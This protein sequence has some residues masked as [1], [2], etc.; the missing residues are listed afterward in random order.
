MMG[1]SAMQRANDFDAV[2]VGLGESGLASACHLAAGGRRVA[3]LDSRPQP[4][5]EAE[6][7]RRHPEVMVR[8]GGIDETLIARAAEIVISPGFDPRHPAIREARRRGQ[9]VI[10]EIELFA[11]SVTAPVMA[12]TG[13]NG[14]STVTR[15]LAAMAEAAG[16]NV[17]AGGNLGPAALTLLETRPEAA[18]FILE[19]SSFQLESTFSLTPQVAAVLNLSPDHLDR[20]DSMAD[21]AAAK[22]RILR[23]AG[24]AV[25]NAD[26]ECVR[27]MADGTLPVSWFSAHGSVEM[28]QWR[29]QRVAGVDWLARDDEP[30]LRQQDLPAMGRHNALNALA[31]LAMGEAAGWPLT[32]MCRALR[33]FRPLPHRGERLGVHRHRLWVNDSK[34]TN[35]AS[36][37]AA[38]AG[39][40]RPVLLIAGGDAKG[41]SFEALAAVLRGRGRAAVVYGRDA[42]DLAAALSPTLPV[43]CVS[44]LDA[45]VAVAQQRSR[46]GDVVLLS[47]ACASLDQYADY[48][49]RG[50]HFRSLVEA[51]A[52]E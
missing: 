26:D 43:D 5:R 11:R 13:S 2:V 49:A 27:G 17:A 18:L 29:L 14:K 47:P 25:L 30:L 20:Y 16:V 37:A 10:G 38:V 50:D 52:D 48:R 3:I 35:V 44:D 12:I 33:A 8:T 41:Q 42:N 9:P 28:A 45:A 51:L 21:Y 23:G 32:P 1:E 40:D 46:P 22:A 4:P 15:M 39:M 24:Q 19:L 31:A 7:R 36:A 6:L 34:A